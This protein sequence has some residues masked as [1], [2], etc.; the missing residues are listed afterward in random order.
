M[1]LNKPAAKRLRQTVNSF[2]GFDSDSESICSSDRGFDTD[3]IADDFVE[4]KG[5][6]PSRFEPKRK[7]YKLN[8]LRKQSHSH[9]RNR[10]NCVG[11]R[12]RESSDS[13][14]L[15]RNQATNDLS[16]AFLA[17]S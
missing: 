13:P 10:A 15:N 8:D 5:E 17:A 2:S 1:P 4:S 12:P 11:R 6:T 9:E 7:F 3:F 16:S 14:S